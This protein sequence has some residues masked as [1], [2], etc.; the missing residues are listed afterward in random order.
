MTV[1]HIDKADKKVLD[2]ETVGGT[3]GENYYSQAFEY[4]KVEVEPETLLRS[5]KK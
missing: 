3:V 2:T 1:N 4:N 5:N